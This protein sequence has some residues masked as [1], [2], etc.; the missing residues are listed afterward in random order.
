M[1]KFG[2]I[3]K[4]TELSD[5]AAEI[6]MAGAEVCA[7]CGTDS[8]WAAAIAD[9][10][11][12]GNV[13]LDYRKLLGSVESDALCI[14]GCEISAVTDAIQSGKHVLWHIPSAQLGENDR[15]LQLLAD[16]H[17]TVLQLCAAE[18]STEI[19]TAEIKRFL[20]KLS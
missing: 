15:Q 14:C 7:V 19:M 17:G 11:N 6:Y 12:I 9:Q 2:L 20:Q 18:S 13:Y 3:G 4:G 10:Y 8:G 16:G 5:C 1:I